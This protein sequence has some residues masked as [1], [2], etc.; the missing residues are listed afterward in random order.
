MMAAPQAP[1]RPRVL[2]LSAL[3]VHPTRSG[4]NLRSFA[5]ASALERHGLDVFVYSLVGR[6][7]EYLARRPSSL[8]TWPG[9]VEEY[10]DRGPLGFVAQFGSYR[11]GLPPLWATAYLRMAAA[12]PGEALMPRRLREKLAWSD[13]VV[14]DF[15]FVHPIFAAPSAQGSLR[16]LSTH[17]LEHRMYDGQHGLKSRTLRAAVRR[18]ELDAAGACDVLVTCCA[19]DKQFFEDNARVRRSILVP[20]GIEP[21]RFRGLEG[22]REGT[23]QALGIGDGVKVFLFTG[24]KYGPNREAFEYLVAFARRHAEMLAGQ[25]IHILVVGS[26]APAPLRAAGLTATGKVDVVEPYFAAADAALNPMASGAGTN[27]KMCEFLA[28]GLPI[29]S[30]RFG[31]R[32][33]ALEDGETAFLFEKEGLAPVLSRVRRLFDED[34]GRLRRMAQDAFARNQRSIDMDTCV[35]Q[36]VEAMGDPRERSVERGRY[37]R[38]ETRSPSELI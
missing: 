36:L 30:T 24:S 17:N 37:A 2:F 19:G 4:G 38:V 11:V 32:G 28:T 6:K 18:V 31:A 9:G 27:V 12:S 25:R 35:Q 29:V 33:F 34:P 5:L 8:Q 15:P 21:R 7:D 13:V 16:V 3:Q 10:V 1:R 20:N 26:V 22:Q 23:R 14:A